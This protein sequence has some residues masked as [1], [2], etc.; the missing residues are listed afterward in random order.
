LAEYL[1]VHGELGI[2]WIADVN[3]DDIAIEQDHGRFRE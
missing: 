1:S 3:Q 2:V